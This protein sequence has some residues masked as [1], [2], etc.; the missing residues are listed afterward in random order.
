MNRVIKELQAMTKLGTEISTWSNA[1][2]SFKLQVKQIFTSA[3]AIV[4]EG[5]RSKILE[6]F[7]IAIHT[8]IERPRIGVGIASI[9]IN[10]G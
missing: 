4:V 1:S 5:L 8:A 10:G 2:Q 7:P 6:R 3:E 9:S